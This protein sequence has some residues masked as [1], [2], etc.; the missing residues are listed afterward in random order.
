MRAKMKDWREPVEL[1]IGGSPMEW[2]T[3]TIPVD[4]LERAESYC[5]E[6]GLS[7]P[8]WIVTLIQQELKRE[9]ENG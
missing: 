5:E 6:R 1:D 4:L 2:Q 9:A 7:L 8:Y 3:L